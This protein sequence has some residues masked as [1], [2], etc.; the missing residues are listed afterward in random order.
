MGG[1]FISNTM[2]DWLLLIA[3]ILLIVIGLI[4]AVV[5]VLPGPPLSFVG[6]LIVHFTRF[7]EFETSTLWIL[8]FLAALVQVLDYI[9]PAWGTKKFGGTKHGA[10]GS[11]I[12]LIIGLFFLPAI[13]PFGIITILAGPFC[14]AWIGETIAGQETNKAL[15]AA[16]GS[17]IGFLTG[18][19]MKL[20]TSIIIAFIFFKEIIVSLFN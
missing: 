15:K 11:I 20:V 6:L 18:T 2:I 13:G 3:S 4:G 5:P 19:L 10:W 9:V 12:G 14:G 1:L 7:A 17:F 8:G 16:F